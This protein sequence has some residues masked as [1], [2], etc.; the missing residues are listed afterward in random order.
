MKKQ[1]LSIYTQFRKAGY[2]AC[3]ALHNAPTDPIENPHIID[4]MAAALN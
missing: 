1:T 3:E 4:L 2:R